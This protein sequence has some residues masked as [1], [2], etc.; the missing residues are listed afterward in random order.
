[1]VDIF[2]AYYDKLKV[3]ELFLKSNQDM[4]TSDQTSTVKSRTEE[5]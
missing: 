4:A 2:D 5:E 1:M 3:L